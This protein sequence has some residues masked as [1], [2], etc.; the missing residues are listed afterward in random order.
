MHL[1]SGQSIY[2]LD[3]LELFFKIKMKIDQIT[4]PYVHDP[5]MYNRMSGTKEL[6]LHG[7]CFDDVPALFDHVELN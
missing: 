2:L 7:C 1:F 4:A 3:A 5:A 6:L